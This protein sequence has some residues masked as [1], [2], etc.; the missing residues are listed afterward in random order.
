MTGK[1][2]KVAIASPNEKTIQKQC[3]DWLRLV[4]FY[5]V[6]IH[7]SL[8]SHKGIADYWIIRKGWWAWIEFKT[9]KGKQS[10]HQ[11][12]FENEVKYQQGRYF[13]VRSLEE[14]QKIIKEA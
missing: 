4:G 1:Q 3:V 6:K 2:K 9:A 8:G 13:V 12:D 14:M 7:Q 5:C 11:I 10:E